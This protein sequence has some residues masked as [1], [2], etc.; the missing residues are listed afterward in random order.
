MD[1]LRS[2]FYAKHSKFPKFSLKLILS[3]GASGRLRHI[4]NRNE[5]TVCGELTLAMGD[6]NCL[7][8]G[9]RRVRSVSGQSNPIAGPRGFGF[10]HRSEPVNGRV[11]RSGGQ[12]PG[13]G[14]LAE[15][16]GEI[17]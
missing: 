15:T 10:I 4:S 9:G 5:D 11:M 12:I 17:A 6:W 3:S 13:Q 2:R 14:F 8:G 1:A 16:A 7:D